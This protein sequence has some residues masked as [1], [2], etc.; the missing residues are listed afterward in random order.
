MNIRRLCLIFLLS[1]HFIIAS[2][3]WTP[4]NSGTLGYLNDVCFHDS[5]NGWIAG[6]TGILL[7]QNGGNT[8]NLVETP[9][10]YPLQGI[11]FIDLENGWAVAYEGTILHSEDGGE[12][13]EA[14][15]TGG[16]ADDLFDVEFIDLDNGWAVGGGTIIHTNNGGEL[17]SPQL[18]SPGNWFVSVSMVGMYGWAAG[19]RNFEQSIIYKTTDGGQHWSEFYVNSLF[20]GINDIKFLDTNNGWFVGKHHGLIMHSSDGGNTWTDQSCSTEVP[21][22]DIEFLDTLHGWT[23]GGREYGS[24]ILVTEDGGASWQEQYR[25]YGKE[26]IGL[27]FSDLNNG[28]AVGYSGFI[29]H[30]ENGGLVGVNK[31]NDEWTDL[32]VHAYPNPFKGSIKIINL[33]DDG[34]YTLSIFDIHNKLVKRSTVFNKSEI[35]LDDLDAGI[36]LMIINIDGKSIAEKI[37][38]IR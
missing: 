23:V 6:N 17:W 26:L 33:P 15:D 11:D 35:S 36:Y 28:W 37:I 32:K 9:T 8:W 10:F 13:W 18:D 30:T 20:N 25:N 7:T 16:S 1:F 31:M 5:L 3:Q 19:T 24:I 21:L 22:E 2:A 14:Q 29:L 4:Q 34:Q 27:A 38:K 12:N